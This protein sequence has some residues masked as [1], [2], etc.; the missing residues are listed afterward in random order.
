MEWTSGLTEAFAVPGINQSFTAQE[1]EGSKLTSAGSSDRDEVLLSS[2]KLS[3]NYPNPFNP[4]TI[5]NYQLPITNFV[6]LKVYDVLGNKVA[7]L[8]NDEKPAGNYSVNFNASNLSSGIYFCTLS[9]G[10]F[11][12]TKK[13]ILIK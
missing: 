1:G 10:K 2:Y 9:S 7:T 6:S 4:S 5:I 11:I 12:E 13:M 3:Q 8:V